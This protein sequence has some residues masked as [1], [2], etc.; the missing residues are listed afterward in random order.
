MGIQNHNFSPKFVFLEYN[1]SAQKI[2][3]GKLFEEGG[4]KGD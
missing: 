1:F 4:H 2:I 3:F